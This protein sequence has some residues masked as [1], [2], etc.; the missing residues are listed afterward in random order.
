VPT[1]RIACAQLAPTLGD[2]EGNRRTSVAAVERAAAEGAGLVVLPELCSSGYVFADS[3][4][5]W[6][7]AEPADGPSVSAWAEAAARLGVVVVGGFAESDRGQL[8]NS[9]ALI[10]PGGVRAVYRKLHLW[11]REKLLFCAGQEPPP[12]VDTAAGRIGLGIC[13][14]LMF[15]EVTRRL[16]LQGADVLAFPTNSPDLGE[17]SMD[18]AVATTTAYVNG[19]FVAVADRCGVERGVDWIGDSLIVAPDGRILARAPTGVRTPVTVTADCQ[20]E[21]ARDKRWGERNDVLGDR[22]IDV[23][24]AL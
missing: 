23:L 17:P 16:A 1:V 7:A 21:S 24:G 13:Y 14:D 4:E 8:F 15:P 20:L 12:V 22:R 18:V 11:D 19:V 2:V 5:A 6:R 9:A 3:A 10:D